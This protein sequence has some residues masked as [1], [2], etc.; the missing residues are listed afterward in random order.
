MNSIVIGTD[1][2]D[3][4]TYLIT[5]KLLKIKTNAISKKK[6]KRKPDR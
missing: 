3:I 5:L 2:N 6:K 4:G 1:W